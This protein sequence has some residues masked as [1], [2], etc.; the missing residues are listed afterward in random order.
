MALVGHDAR[1]HVQFASGAFAV[2]LL[3]VDEGNDLSH[4]GVVVG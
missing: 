2:V 4:L 3:Y 1:R